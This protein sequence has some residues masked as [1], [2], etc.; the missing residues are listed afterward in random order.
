MELRAAE[1]SSEGQAVFMSSSGCSAQSGYQPSRFQG[2]QAIAGTS[3]RST[4]VVRVTVAVK[5]PHDHGSSS[6]GNI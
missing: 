5:R 2:E 1:A 3:L 4:V 6:T